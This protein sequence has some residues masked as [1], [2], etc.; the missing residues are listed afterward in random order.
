MVLSAVATSRSKTELIEHYAEDYVTKPF[1][2]P[3]LVARVHRVL[4]RLNERIPSELLDLGTGPVAGTSPPRGD[5]RRA[6]GRP[7]ADRDATAGDA[8]REPRHDDHHRSAPGP[9][10]ERRRRRRSGVRVGGD[11]PAAAQDRGRSGRSPPS[12]DRPERRLPAG[13]RRLTRSRAH[14]SALGRQGRHLPTPG[15]RRPSLVRGRSRWLCS[16]SRHCAP[17]RTSSARRRSPRRG[18]PCAVSSA[19][20]ARDD[21]GPR[22]DGRQLRDLA[23]APGRDRATTTSNRSGAT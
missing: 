14:G 10:L 6:G 13:R 21:V 3:E 1:D 4:R 8:G 12:P 18:P 2:Y 5:R 17:S 9:G 22:R 20:L 19:V 23:G 7:V 15:H 11:P 16:G